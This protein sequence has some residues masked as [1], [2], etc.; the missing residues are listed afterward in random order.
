MDALND[1]AERASK[2][3]EMNRYLLCEVD[4]VDIPQGEY[5]GDVLTE[6]EYESFLTN[7]FATMEDLVLKTLGY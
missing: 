3:A 5:G 1:P 7:R 4:E 6:D 2:Q